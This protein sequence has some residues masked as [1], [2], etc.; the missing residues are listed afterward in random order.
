[1]CHPGTA[2]KEENGKVV[3]QKVVLQVGGWGWGGG[4]DSLGTHRAPS[5]VGF[6]KVF[7][8]LHCQV[9]LQLVESVA[10]FKIQSGGWNQPIEFKARM[11]NLCR[12]FL[13]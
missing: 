10:F 6:Y 8:A 9:L 13:L 2:V 12:V 4:L 1:M 5:V 11:K 3:P 7:S